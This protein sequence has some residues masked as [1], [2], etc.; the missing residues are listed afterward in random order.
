MTKTKVKE[1][2]WRTGEEM[3][4]ERSINGWLRFNRDIEVMDIKYHTQLVDRDGDIFE[5][6]SALIIYDEEESE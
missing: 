3:T 6:N 1:F 5:I 2:I 4:L